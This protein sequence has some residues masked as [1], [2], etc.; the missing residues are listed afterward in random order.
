MRRLERPFFSCNHED[1]SLWR[2][3]VCHIPYAGFSL[4]LGFVFLSM[5]KFIG[6]SSIKPTDLRV[7]YLNLFHAFH[8][9][10]IILVVPLFSFF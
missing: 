1:S 5:V 8:Y 7:G 9:L 10:H 6:L 2:E 3:I 4:A